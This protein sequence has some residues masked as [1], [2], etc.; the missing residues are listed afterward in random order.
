MSPLGHSRHPDASGSPQERTQMRVLRQEAIKV[1]DAK[2]AH[3]AERHRRAWRVLGLDATRNPSI[4]PPSARS[5]GL[6]PQ[7]AARKDLLTM[8]AHRSEALN[9]R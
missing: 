4:P 6:P 7:P 8:H 1:M 5:P 3:V 9:W 2:L